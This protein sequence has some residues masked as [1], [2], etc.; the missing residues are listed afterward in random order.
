MSVILCQYMCWAASPQH[1]LRILPSHI[2]GVPQKACRMLCA[3]TKK[4]LE[5]KTKLPAP[6]DLQLLF[7]AGLKEG[8]CKLGFQKCSVADSREKSI[9]SIGRVCQG[10]LKAKKVPEGS[11]EVQLVGSFSHRKISEPVNDLLCLGNGDCS[12][13]NLPVRNPP[14]TLCLMLRLLPWV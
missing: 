14:S 2:A 5:V 6:S 3:T 11:H 12:V 8:S 4:E 13:G 10:G 9:H 7:S 1:L